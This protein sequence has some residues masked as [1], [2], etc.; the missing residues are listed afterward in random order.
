MADYFGQA[1]R[2][3]SNPGIVE[4]RRTDQVY[5]S[6]AS[7]TLQI[8][9]Q[10][11]THGSCLRKQYY[12]M[13]SVS[14]SDPEQ[15][16]ATGPAVI[17]S[18]M[19]DWVSDVFGRGGL[20]AQAEVPL[21]IPEIK[22]SGRVDGILKVNGELIGVEVKTVEG[23]Y[24]RKGTIDSRRNAPFFPRLYHL[25]Q[26]VVYAEHFASQGITKWQLLYVDRANGDYHGHDITY[27]GPETITVNGEPTS[28]TPKKIFD[29]WRTLW[30]DIDNKTLPPRDYEIQYS[31]QRLQSMAQAGTLNKADTE[32]VLKGKA[33]DKGDANCRYCPWRTRCWTVDV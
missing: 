17:G 27:G 18:I 7:V 20:L 6:D 21:W 3:I 30:A 2:N 16:L 9:N 25:T 19:H 11:E 26:A 28:I 14:Q 4:T 29:R 33:V 1:L 31:T 10:R 8:G 13:T 12:R 24:G 15:R 23:Y 22:L 5:A 32:K